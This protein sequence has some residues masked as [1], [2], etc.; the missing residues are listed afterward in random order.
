MASPSAWLYRWLID[1]AFLGCGVP[2]IKFVLMI[3]IQ[4]CVTGTQTLFSHPFDKYATSWL[5]T[6]SIVLMVPVVSKTDIE[7]STARHMQLFGPE[8]ENRDVV[9]GLSDSFPLSSLDEDWLLQLQL[10]HKTQCL[11]SQQR[12]F[13]ICL[14]RTFVFLPFQRRTLLLLMISCPRYL[15]FSLL[16]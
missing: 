10:L 3:L 8:W 1:K 4:W 13:K 2:P 15:H 7:T 6:I 5:S 9:S 16:A 12:I 11:L 14:A